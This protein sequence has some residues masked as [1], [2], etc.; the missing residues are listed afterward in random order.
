MPTSRASA[1]WEGSFKEGAG[2]FQAKSGTFRGRYSYQ[3]RFVGAAG[4][5]PEELIAAAHA[6]CLSMALTASLEKAG[7]P[8]TRIATDAA[9]T[10][11][12]VEGSARITTITLQVRGTVPGMN[13]AAFRQ[14]AESAKD[15]CP[16]SKALKGNVAVTL[17]ATLES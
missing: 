6:S 10:I 11:D 4:T 2:E 8:A 7:T 15:N 16:V 17:E 12:I 5:T 9:C 3:T 1:V 13:A 14:A